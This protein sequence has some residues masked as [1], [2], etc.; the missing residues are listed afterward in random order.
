MPRSVATSSSDRRDARVDV[1]DG[2]EVDAAGAPVDGDPRAV[3]APPAAGELDVVELEAERG[4]DGRDGVTDRLDRRVRRLTS[5]RLPRVPQEKTWAAA[6]VP[7]ASDRHGRR[8]LPT[9]A[10]P[11]AAETE[12]TIDTRHRPRSAGRTRPERSRPRPRRQRIVRRRTSR[13]A[14]RARPPRAARSVQSAGSLSG[15]QRRKRALWRKRPFISP[16]YAT[17]HDPLDAQRL[18]RHV[19]VGVPAVR[20]ARHALPAFGRLA[21]G[22][23]PVAPRVVRRAR[24]PAAAAAPRARWSRARRRHARLATPTWCSTPSSSYRPRSSEPTPLPSLCTRKPATT[25]SHVRSCFTFSIVRSPGRY[26]SAS[27]LATTPSNPAPSKR[28]NQSAA[29]IAVAS[30]RA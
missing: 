11:I 14:R 26:G 24:S 2:V 23:G 28:R 12:P 30:S 10:E 16:S 20:A 3:R 8:K 29:T 7:A 17:S 22:F 19:L 4:D 6:H 18:P 21:R 1:G 5:A 9:A 15:R 13:A 27:G 25:Q